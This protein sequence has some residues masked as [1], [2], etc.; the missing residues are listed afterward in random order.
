MQRKYFYWSIFIPLI[1]LQEGCKVN[2][3]PPVSTSKL[4]YLVVEGYI[5]ANG[6]TTINL[7]R[8]RNITWGDTAR[9]QYELNAKVVIENSYGEVFPLTENRE[10][11]YSGF[12]IFN[13]VG[14]KYRLRIIT[15]DNKEYLSDL[16]SLKNSPPLDLGWKFN[17]EGDVQVYANSQDAT[18]KTHFYRWIY[19]ETWEFHTPFYSIL[20]YNPVDS[21]VI[22]RT[23]PVNVCYRTTNSSNIILGSSAKLKQ[24]VIHE[25]PV[26]LVPDHD[27][28][29]SVLYSAFVTEYALDS[30]GYNYWNAMK[31]NTENVGSIFDPQPNLTRGNIHST[32]DSSELVIGYI[33]AGTT[34]QERIFIR[35]SELPADW[36]EIP[37]CIVTEVRNIKDSLYDNFHADAFVPIEVGQQ[38][39][40]G[41]V[42]TYLSSSGMCV[43]CTLT[44][45]LT[46]PSFWP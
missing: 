9:Y 25:G 13:S 42:E 15:S 22:D 43:D 35:N 36:N 34:Q 7:S 1:L 32:T 33:G 37:D 14:A 21:T 46:K 24:D 5:N 29:I 31:S 10:G 17:D 8:T 23:V 20:K 12:Y 4:H 3:D 18:N 19:S 2:Y 30:A 40:S 39:L 38:S 27:R 41:G 28:R 45:T 11:V 26:V 16:V 44:G 6:E